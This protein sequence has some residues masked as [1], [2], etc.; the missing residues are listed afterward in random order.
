[1]K[2]KEWRF[3]KYLSTTDMQ[4][5]VN[6]SEK[7]AREEGKN[8]RFFYNGVPLLDQKIQNFKKRKTTIETCTET[9]S[10]GKTT[11]L[12]VNQVGI[13]II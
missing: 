8:T 6:K 12:S 3:D 5:I 7:R 1:M 2:L 13:T 4:I 9:T 11:R 10:A